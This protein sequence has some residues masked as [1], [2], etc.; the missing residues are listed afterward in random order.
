MCG[1]A[2]LT[3]ALAVE[4]RL[5]VQ[6][7]GAVGDG[8]TD[9]TPALRAAVAAAVKAGPGTTLVFD[10]KTY[11]LD[12]SAPFGAHFRLTRVSDLTIEGNGALLLA[13]PYNGIFD[14]FSCT[15]V[16]LRGFAIDYAPLAFTQG[17]I[18]QVDVGQACFDLDLEPGYPL[19]P[20]DGLVKQMIGD[21]GWQ[22]GSVIDPV[23]R[24]RRW[25]VADHYF[26]E[27]VTPVA[28]RVYRVKVT[29]PYAAQLARVRP[30]DR[31]FLPLL[32]TAA[33]E[34]THG[35]NIQV[36]G[37][38]GCWLEDITMYAARN[39]MNYSIS[40]NEGLITLKHCKITFKPDSTR[41]CTTWRDG[42]HCKDNRVGPVFDGCF[43]E[44]M[45]DDSINISAN[46]AM[47]VKVV[48]TN[49]FV[50]T[51]ASF[52]GGDAVWVVDPSSGRTLAQTRVAH[53][54][55]RDQKRVV[56]LE[57]P[58]EGVITGEKVAHRDIKSTHFYNMSYANDGFIVRQCVFKPQR[59]HAVLVRCSHGIIEDNTIDGVGGAAVCMGNEIGGFYEGPFPTHNI[60]RNNTIRN[61]QIQAIRLYTSLLKSSVAYTGDIRVENN[62]IT[63][64]PGQPGIWINKA[65]DI[66]LKN[67]RIL[68]QQGQT[69]GADG[70]RV[71]ASTG[72]RLEP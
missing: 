68:D 29:P 6:A 48:S 57:D 46:T 12:K 32:I 51:S 13:H 23:E 65:R 37:S 70:I 16:T 2:A 24:H 34:R 52:N 1:W 53:V 26:I 49:A 9:D 19:P 15:N 45:L 17:A 43:F 7:F 3:S 21:G 20:A 28:E 38:T 61:T 33:G 59:R 27:S 36:I 31:F 8:V 69:V 41:I 56:T 47:A 5:H 67:N 62:T 58:V 25:D 40:H 22:W 18:R 54:E 66:L 39:G 30:G 14:L 44:G 50:L 10:K 55:R 4:S 63:V 64:L 42:M 60:I 71:E 72:I 35:G 11:R